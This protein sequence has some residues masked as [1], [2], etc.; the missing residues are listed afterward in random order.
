MSKIIIGG[1]IVGAVQTNVYYLHQEG[2]TDCIVIDPADAGEMI[3]KAIEG[4]GLHVGA[5]LLTHGHYDHIWGVDELRQYS[6]APVIACEKEREFLLDPM[7]NHSGLH[8]RP[9]TV[10]ADRYVHDGEEFTVCDITLRC[11]WTPGHTHG[12]CCYYIEQE[13]PML[14][15]GDTL[16]YESVGR[17]DL[18]TGSMS[19]LVH[20]V[21]EKLFTLPA[22]TVVYPGHGG[23]TSIGHEIEN[24][25]FV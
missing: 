1:Y 10:T 22:N 7:E 8:N 14:L 2:S 24:N 20:S 11:I 9:C 19:E 25:Y 17:T 13:E 4:Q 15:C 6:K 23:Q 12:S 18:P 5:I 21:R 3:G 16:F